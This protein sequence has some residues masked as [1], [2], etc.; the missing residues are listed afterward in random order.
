MEKVSGII[1]STPSG[2]TVT[3]TYDRPQWVIE[4]GD[5]IHTVDSIPQMMNYLRTA[6]TWP[7]PSRIFD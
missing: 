1:Y 7:M 3:V 2:G 4:D 6:H 5:T